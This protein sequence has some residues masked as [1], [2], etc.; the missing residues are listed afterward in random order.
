MRSGE[1][2][3][4]TADF[5][6]GKPNGWLRYTAS[7]NDELVIAPASYGPHGA[8]ASIHYTIVDSPFGRIL[9]A[10]TAHGLCWIALATP[11]ENLEAELRGDYSAAQFVRDNAGLAPLTAA[12][13]AFVDGQSAEI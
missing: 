3:A 11:D 10:A 2:E 5:T 8:G 1:L 9:L 13:L 6:V 4:A 7:G 12:I